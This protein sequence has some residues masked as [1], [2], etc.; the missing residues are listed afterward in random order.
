[1]GFYSGPLSAARCC[2]AL[3]MAATAIINIELVERLLSVKSESG[4][5]R[6]NKK[7]KQISRLAKSAAKRKLSRRV[8]GP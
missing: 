2:L 1:M 5:R 8:P 3:Q 7:N 6:S 4:A